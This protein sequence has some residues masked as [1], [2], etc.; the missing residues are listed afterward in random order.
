MAIDPSLAVREGQQLD[1]LGLEDIPEQPGEIQVAEGGRLGPALKP[2]VRAFFKMLGGVGKRD[3]EV[4]GAPRLETRVTGAREV[5]GAQ[6]VAHD[7]QNIWRRGFH[8]SL[9][10]LPYSAA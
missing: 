2:A 6:L 4:I 3:P 5:V 8:D 1:L 9:G 7:E 10:V